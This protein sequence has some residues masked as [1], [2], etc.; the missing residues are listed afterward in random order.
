M[1]LLYLKSRSELWLW[2]WDI[3]VSFCALLC[4]CNVSKGN[5]HRMVAVRRD[6]CGSPSP[7]PLQKQ[8]H[9]ERAARDLVQAGLEY[10]QSRKLHNLPKQPVP[11]LHH[12]DSKKFFLM[13]R[14]N[15]LGFCLC[16]LPLVLSLGDTIKSLAPSF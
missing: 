12:P 10:L 6:L 1:I 13:L 9:P 2:T 7:A 4:S 8:V 15:I 5:N 16:L 14:W 3:W 11:V